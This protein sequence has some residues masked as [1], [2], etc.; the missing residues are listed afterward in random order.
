MLVLKRAQFLERP[1]LR[2][3]LLVPEPEHIPAPQPGVTAH[4]MRGKLTAF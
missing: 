1:P 2:C 4:P 3:A